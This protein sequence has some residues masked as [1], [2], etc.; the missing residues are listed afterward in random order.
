MTDNWVRVL[1]SYSWSANL[2]DFSDSCEYPDFF[3]SDITSG[4]TTELEKKFRRAVDEG[5]SLEIAGEVCFWKLYGQGR[6][7]NK[8]TSELLKHLEDGEWEGFSQAVRELSLRPSYEN[9]KNLCSR[10]GQAYGFAIPITFLS[11]YNP[12]EYPMVDKLVGTWW[13]ENKER[14]GYGDDPE[15]KQRSDGYIPK[16]RKNWDAYLAWSGFCR[17]YSEAL[18]SETGKD[19]RARD[20]E[21]AVFTA[22]ERGLNLDTL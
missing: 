5:G 17:G 10:C 14:H 20:V 19:W 21:K 22:Q 11:F 12:Q 15:F 3:E 13:N 18:S 7:R 2:Q 8:K 6:V 9:L 1:K 16:S 4:E